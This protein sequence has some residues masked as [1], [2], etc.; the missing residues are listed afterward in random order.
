MVDHSFMHRIL[1]TS[2]GVFKKYFITYN[3]KDI[4]DTEYLPWVTSRAPFG[5]I[6]EQN[7]AYLTEAGIVDNWR[8]D[9]QIYLFLDG[10]KEYHDYW[11]EYGTPEKNHTNY[12]QRAIL[13]KRDSNSAEL[14]REG[15]LSGWTRLKCFFSCME[16]VYPFRYLVI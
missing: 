13:N 3:H 5:V 11:R 9:Y 4:L 8:Q 10:V 2:F 16:Y 14:V 6:F 7:L 12:F 15:C 1:E